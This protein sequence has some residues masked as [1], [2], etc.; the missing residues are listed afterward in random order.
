MWCAYASVYGVG[1][2]VDRTK[3]GS[4]P[5]QFALSEILEGACHVVEQHQRL[6][7]RYGVVMHVLRMKQVAPI[8]PALLRTCTRTRTSPLAP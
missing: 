7:L 4:V 8:G 3:R 6:A 2:G 1:C 5:G